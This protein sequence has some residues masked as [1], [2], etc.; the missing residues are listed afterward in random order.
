[1]RQ[2]DAAAWLLPALLALFFGSGAAGLIYQ[3]LWLRLLALVFGVTVWAAS[4]VLASFMAGLALGSLGAGRLADRL[5]NPLLWYGLAEILVGLSALASPA[6]LD[7]VER[8]YVRLYPALPHDPALLTALRFGLSFLVLLVPTTLMGATLPIIVKSSLL[9]QHGLGRSVSLLYATNTAGA[10][11]G[12]LLAGFVLVGGVG[13]AASFR[14]AAGLN[15]LVGL[16]A[17]GAARARRRLRPE[18]A[19]PA[20]AEDPPLVEDRYPPGVRRLVLALF[21]LSGFAALALEVIWFRVL[22]LY[23]VATTYAFTI[24][25]ATV[26]LGIAAGSYLAALFLRR[27]ANWLAVLAGLEMAVA[28]AAVLS[29]TAIPLALDAVTWMEALLGRT[30][31]LAHSRIGSAAIASFAALFPAAL[32]MGVAFPVG[33][34][35]WAGGDEGSPRA[36]ER[37][38]LFYSLNVFGAILG[39]AAAG[40]LLLPWLGS[41]T[42]LVAVASLSL[43]GGLLLLAASRTRRRAVYGG[44]G[45]LLFLA[46]VAAMPDPFAAALERRFPGD[47]L[48]WQEEGVQTTVTVHETPAG[49]RVLYMDGLHQTNDEL[50]VLHWMIG[51]L[52][53]AVHPAP[54]D[55]LVVGLGGG[56]TPGAVSLHPGANVEVVELSGSVVRG[57]AWFRHINHDVLDRPNVRLLVDDG[58]NHLLLTRKRYDVITADV[59][60]PFHA[61]AGN[62]YSVEYYRLA[63]RALKD[64]GVMLQWLGWLPETQHKLIMRTFLH[65]FPDATLWYNG[66]LLVGTKEPLQLDPAAFERRLQDPGVRAA[67]ATVGLDGFDKLVAHYWAGPEELH[68]YVGEGPVLTDDRPMV[69]YF[70]SLPR[71]ERGADLTGVRG[72]PSRHLAPLSGAE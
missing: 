71:R 43:L 3:V 13:I 63:R 34:H 50:A 27:Q 4:T 40:F 31:P 62:L 64:D 36:G 44:A 38:G 52:P 25:L 66:T 69:E 51:H 17:I 35:V 56:A 45:A 8:L 32:L 7:L 15:V 46:T 53:M 6:A 57:A 60:L 61:G 2:P 9:E 41:R 14:L 42:S 55:V 5:R 65:V 1:R 23:L 48:L 11:A 54:R 29:L 28:V 10:V 67:L 19:R 21:A 59:I 24:M 47:R 26:L 72:D 39:S 22:V 70:L 20:A 49:V 68:R 30:L 58:R 12:A 18:G 16:A 37:I 33:L